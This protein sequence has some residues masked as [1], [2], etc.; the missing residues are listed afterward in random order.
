MQT[1]VTKR[2]H[3]INTH[4]NFEEVLTNTSIFRAYNVVV[5]TRRAK[6]FTSCKWLGKV[7][8]FQK[9]TTNGLE[10]IKNNP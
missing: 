5:K 4:T 3:I 2:L 7:T 1:Y 10:V 6:R 8:Q 9:A